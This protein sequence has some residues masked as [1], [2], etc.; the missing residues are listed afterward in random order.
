MFLS[1]WKL[2]R[3]HFTSI[4]V[5]YHELVWEGT[6][7]VLNF[8]FILNPSHIPCI[9]TRLPPQEGLLLW[10]F[11]S[12]DGSICFSHCSWNTWPLQAW[13]FWQVNLGMIKEHQAQ[14]MFHSVRQGHWNS[15]ITHWNLQNVMP[16]LKVICQ[17]LHGNG[18]LQ[19]PLRTRRIVHPD[20]IILLFTSRLC[21]PGLTATLEKAWKMLT[22]RITMKIPSNVDHSTLK[23]HRKAKTTQ[24]R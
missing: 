20:D 12:L 6:C 13:R 24:I 16:I 21:N 11:C 18:C 17:K 9:G 4:I 19:G 22:P 5:F 23:C 10:W 7:I 14:G 8:K 2:K 1:C 15:S 3:H